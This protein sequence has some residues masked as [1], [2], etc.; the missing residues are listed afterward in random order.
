MSSS[1]VTTQGGGEEEGVKV[2]APS[3]HLRPAGNLIASPFSLLG[4]KAFLISAPTL[5]I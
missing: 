3:V 1:V 4:H 2:V 5:N